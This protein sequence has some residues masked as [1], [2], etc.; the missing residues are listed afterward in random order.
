MGAGIS[1]MHYIGMA[2]MRLPAICTY[3]LRIV[4]ASILIA[5]VVSVVALLLAFRLRTRI[6]NSA[7]QKSPAPS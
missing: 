3:D 4:A 5:V 7:R 1:A 2:A 6:A